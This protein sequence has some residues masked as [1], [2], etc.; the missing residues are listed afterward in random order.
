M[1]LHRKAIA[2]GNALDDLVSAR[3]MLRDAKIDSEKLTLM[4]TMLPEDYKSEDVL[5]T[6]LRL[7]PA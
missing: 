6:M 4:N 1:K 7:F 2:V 3:V 5:K